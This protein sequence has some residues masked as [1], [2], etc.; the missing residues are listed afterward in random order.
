MYKYINIQY[1]FF[2]NEFIY[3]KIISFY[4][5]KYI[6]FKIRLFRLKTEITELNSVFNIRF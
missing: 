3:S 5:K 2:L 4:I 1:K 6:F